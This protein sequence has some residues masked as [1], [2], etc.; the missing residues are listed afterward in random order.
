MPEVHLTRKTGKKIPTCSKNGEDTRQ[1]QYAKKVRI[2]GENRKNYKV[3]D[4]LEFR[5]DYMG[6]LRA[7]NSRYI[8]K[9]LK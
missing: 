8:E 4:L 3:G 2:L 9:R 1:Y 7:I 6:T 5:M